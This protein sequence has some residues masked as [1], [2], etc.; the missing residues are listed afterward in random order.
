MIQITWDFPATLP[1]GQLE[2]NPEEA[3]Q[4]LDSSLSLRAKDKREIINGLQTD[5]PTK[6]VT[7]KNVCRYRQM[8]LG[9]E[10]ANSFVLTTNGVRTYGEKAYPM[11]QKSQ[12]LA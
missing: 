10:G 5:S 1:P 7:S 11:D 8:S 6:V 9:V 2:F 3:K 12:I 4:T